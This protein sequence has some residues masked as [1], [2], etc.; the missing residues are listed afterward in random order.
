MYIKVYKRTTPI[1]IVILCNM[2]FYLFNKVYIYIY[3]SI[4]G[5]FLFLFYHAIIFYSVL[6]SILFSILFYSV[7]YS[8]LHLT[9]IIFIYSISCFLFYHAILF[10]SVLYSILYSILFY[11]ATCLHY[12]YIGQFLFSILSCNSILFCSLFDSIS[13]LY[14]ILFYS[15]LHLANIIFI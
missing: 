7:F 13:I 15:I 9:N 12:F 2:I 10:Y 5:Q 8:I 6:Y 14:T 11:I 1:L 4:K 3:K